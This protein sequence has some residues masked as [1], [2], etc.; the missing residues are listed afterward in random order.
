[1][2]FRRRSSIIPDITPSVIPDV[3]PNVIPD[4]TPSVIPD[5][6]NRESSQLK[7]GNTG[8]PLTTS[9][10]DGRG[11]AGMT[12]GRRRMSQRSLMEKR[13]DGFAWVL[14]IS[15]ETHA[16]FSATRC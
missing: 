9:G 16:V 12:E 4:V 7:R 6:C 10:N 1:M 15:A 2:S 13:I 5:V 8:F 3:T 14:M 11:S